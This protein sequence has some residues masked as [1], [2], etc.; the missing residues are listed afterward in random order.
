LLTLLTNWHRPYGCVGQ[1]LLAKCL[2]AKRFSSERRETREGAT[3]HMFEKI[4]KNVA[5]AP[6]GSCQIKTI[7]KWENEKNYEIMIEKFQKN[8]SNAE[9]YFYQGILTKREGSVH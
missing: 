9:N 1:T 8:I 3:A 6:L 5:L 2:S 7:F 4:P